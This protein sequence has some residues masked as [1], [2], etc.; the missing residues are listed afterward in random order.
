MFCHSKCWLY[1]IL[2]IILFWRWLFCII[3]YLS[4]PNSQCLSTS[5]FLE[6]LASSD[7][8]YYILA[9]KINLVLRGHHFFIPLKRTICYV[10]WSVN[11]SWVIVSDIKRCEERKSKTNNRKSLC[12]F[13]SPN[14]SKPLKVV[15]NTMSIITVQVAKKSY[16]DC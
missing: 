12:I 1:L 10:Q 3:I 9:L 4:H 5:Y 16:C 7:E 6:R 14:L 8:G 2:Q 11:P 15:L 13:L